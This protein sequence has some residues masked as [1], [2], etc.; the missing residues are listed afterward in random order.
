M[1][2][3]A[4]RRKDSLGKGAME[5]QQRKYLT[6]NTWGACQFGLADGSNGGG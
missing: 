2:G 4:R 3:K 6:F 5:E 1:Y